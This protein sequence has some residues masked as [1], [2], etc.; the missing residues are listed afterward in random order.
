MTSVSSIKQRIAYR[1]A[2]SCTSIDALVFGPSPSTSPYTL[3]LPTSTRSTSAAASPVL[4][5][6][7]VCRPA[8]APIQPCPH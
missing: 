2:P 8:F 5:T 4:C 6:T 7:S 3:L 1:P